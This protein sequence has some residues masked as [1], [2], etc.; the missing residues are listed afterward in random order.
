MKITQIN[1]DDENDLENLKNE[2]ATVEKR[3]ESKISAA[4]LTLNLRDLTNL[5]LIQL[6]KTALFEGKSHKI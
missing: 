6:K 3:L 2:L 1:L 4:E 5:V